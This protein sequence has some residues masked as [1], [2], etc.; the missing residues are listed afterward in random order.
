MVKWFAQ[1]MTANHNMKM[2]V[3]DVC[4]AVS[5]MPRTDYLT[6]QIHNKSLLSKRRS[7]VFNQSIFSTHDTILHE[8]KSPRKKSDAS[9]IVKGLSI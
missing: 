9:N 4:A 7:G 6:K 5:P 1:A 2:S 8:P 3:T